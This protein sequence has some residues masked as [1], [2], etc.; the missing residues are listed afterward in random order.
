MPF[1][2]SKPYG[3]ASKGRGWRK[4]IKGSSLFGTW[5]FFSYHSLSQLVLITWAKK[6]T[7]FA[8]N[9]TVH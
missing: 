2:S 4:V 3:K 6:E 5:I 1:F 7:L 8:T 9:V